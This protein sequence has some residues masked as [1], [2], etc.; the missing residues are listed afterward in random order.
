[1]TADRTSLALRV[2]V[3]GPLT[4]HVKDARWTC[5]AS[6]AGPSGPPGAVEAAAPSGPSVWSMLSGPKSPR[7]TRCRRSTTMSPGSVAISD[8]SPTVSSARVPGTGYTSRPTSWTWLRRAG[9]AR[10]ASSRRP[11]PQRP[12]PSLAREALD[13]WRGP[14][15]EEFRMPSLRSRRVGGPRRAAPPA[16]STTG[17]VRAGCDR[18]SQRRRQML[19]PRLQRL[20]C[21]SGQPAAACAPWPPTVAQQR[22]WRRLRRSGDASPMR[23]AST[24]ARP[25]ESWSRWWRRA[26]PARG[27]RSTRL[28]PR[29]AWWPDRTAPWSDVSTT[30]R[31]CCDCSAT[32]AT[33]TITGPGGVGKTRLALD[34]AA[35]PA[36][37]PGTAATWSRST[38]PPSTGRSAC[39]R[40]SR[41]PSACGP[42]ASS[43]P[44]TWPRL[45]QTGTCCSCSTTASTYRTRAG[46]SSS[47]SAASTAAYACW[48]RPGSPCTCP[49]EY[50]VR[51]QP[52]PVPRDATDL[53]ALRRHPGVR[54]FVEHAR[55]DGPTS[56]SAEEDADHLVEV[57][58][59]LDGL[60]LGIELAARQVD[61][62]AAT[63]RTRAARPRA[64]PRDRESRA[65][66]RPAA[67]APRHHRLVVPLLDDAGQ[68]LLRALAPFPGGVDLTP[69]RCWRATSRIRRAARPAPPTGRRIPGRR[70]PDVRPLPAPVH[71]AGVPARRAP[72]TRASSRKPRSASSTAAS[73]WP[74]TWGT[75]CTVRTNRWRIGCSATSSTTCG[76]PATWRSPMGATTCGSGSRSPSTRRPHGA[77][78]ASCGPGPSSCRSTRAWPTTPTGQPCSV[79]QPRRLG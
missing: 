20:R 19:R 49:G 70:G 36:A 45:W 28:A 9:L 46:S 17:G 14:A 38:W 73:L 77:T 48:P 58:R 32:N 34:V 22:P 75:G 3:L 60:P 47:P 53:D 4:L 39:A 33:V 74:G 31:R 10:G 41:R 21:A 63:R 78:C 65:R 29:R 51:L 40:R 1:M 23:P 2:E 18:R 43:E 27:P 5:R 59:R 54:A 67:H 30:A 71:R 79:V 61:R 16:R 12:R 72:P 76:R 8:P 37:A 55:R 35:D 50:V 11:R 15:L 52:L 7:S 42:P 13:L 44:T 66:R 56:I 64:R 57:L 25:C 62:D 69:S 6:P 26:R 24:R 68:R